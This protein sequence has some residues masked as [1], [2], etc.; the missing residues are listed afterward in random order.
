MAHRFHMNFSGH[1][2]NLESLEALQRQLRSHSQQLRAQL[3]EDAPRAETRM[4]ETRPMQTRP[5]DTHL[6]ERHPLRPM[7]TRLPEHPPETRPCPARLPSTRE[8]Q[9]SL[10][11]RSGSQGEP[12]ASGP[13]SSSKVQSIAS[14]IEQLEDRC[15]ALDQRNRWL[16][17]RLMQRL[18]EWIARALTGNERGLLG[19]AFHAWKKARR[20]LQLE[21]L[22]QRQTAQLEAQQA[23]AQRLAEAL[24]EEQ[25]RRS[26]AEAAAVRGRS[27]LEELQARQSRLAEQ[28]QASQEELQRMR[29]RLKEDL[30]AGARSHAQRCEDLAFEAKQRRPSNSN[31]IH[32]DDAVGYSLD[33]H[34]EAE[35]TLQR[36]HQLLQSR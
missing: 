9:P 7:E 30:A 11:L 35:S 8:R 18:Q 15:D 2:E 33:V 29:R 6:P 23:L 25:S 31:G 22:L 13:L 3:A 26:E 24:Q 28:R 32:R 34:A 21:Q 19:T 10:S 36:A 1:E 12:E 17:H 16:T 20:G 14:D 5:L 4:P 27:Q